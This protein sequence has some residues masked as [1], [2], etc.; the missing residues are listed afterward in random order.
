MHGGGNGGVA[1]MAYGPPVDTFA[2]LQISKIFKIFKFLS[3]K[4]RVIRD[5]NKKSLLQITNKN[6]QNLDWQSLSMATLPFWTFSAKVRKKKLKWK[7][8]SKT[9]KIK[10]A[11]TNWK[12]KKNS[13][14]GGCARDLAREHCRSV[15]IT[16]LRSEKLSG[17][18]SLNARGRAR[19][20]CSS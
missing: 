9:A 11:F 20:L 2:T 5:Y 8:F 15:L 17:V 18:L 12:A 7:H 13:S 16:A 10:M 14:C 4:T 19:E 1:V 3:S 6:S